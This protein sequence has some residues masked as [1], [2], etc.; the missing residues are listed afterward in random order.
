MAATAATI[1]ITLTDGQSGP[2]T[3]GA[4]TINGETIGFEEAHW[5]EVI[6][7]G[8]TSTGWLTATANDTGSGTPNPVFSI[9]NELNSFDGSSVLPYDG[10]IIVMFTPGTDAGGGVQGTVLRP[11]MIEGRQSID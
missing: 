3:G 7:G 9:T 2:P 1:T 5:I 10:T 11:A 8:W 4:L 6:N